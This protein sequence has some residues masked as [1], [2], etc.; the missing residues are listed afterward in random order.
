MQPDVDKIRR[1]SAREVADRLALLDGTEVGGRHR[2]AAYDGSHWIQFYPDGAWHNHKSDWGGDCISLVQAHMAGRPDYRPATADAHFGEAIRQIAEA[3]SLWRSLEGSRR[4]SHRLAKSTRPSSSS[5]THAL[6]MAGDYRGKVDGKREQAEAL[7]TALGVDPERV[8]LCPDGAGT[9]ALCWQPAVPWQGK[10]VSMR[11]DGSVGGWTRERAQKFARDEAALRVVCIDLDGIT[12]TGERPRFDL[13]ERAAGDLARMGLP[14]TAL[15]WSSFGE[16]E[17]RAKAHLYFA[18]TQR[19]Q[20]PAEWRSWWRLVTGSLA[21]VVSNWRDV[22]ERERELLAVD[23]GTEQITR[24]VRLPGYKK[25]GSSWAGVVEW[26]RP[27]V[28]VDFAAALETTDVTWS[29]LKG[30]VRH[31]FTLGERCTYTKRGGDEPTEVLL[32]RRVWPLARYHTPERDDAGLYLRVETLDGLTRYVTVS[33]G[34]L[35]DK[36]RRMGATQEI[37]GAGAQVPPVAGD[38]LMSALGQLY[39]RHE[40]L[41]RRGVLVARAGWHDDSY[42]LGAEVIGAGGTEVL[43]DSTSEM[44]RRRGAT[45]GSLEGWREQVVDRCTTPGLRLALGASLA[46]ALMR[47]LQ[48]H[49]FVLHVAGPSSVGKSTCAHVAA[50]VWGEPS[51][52]GV[53]QSWDTT[54]RAL[55][56]L[57]ELAQDACLV[58]DEVGRW[59][60]SPEDLAGALHALGGSEGRARL[61]QDGALS[62]QRTWHCT[63]VSTGEVRLMDL[64][65]DHMQGGHAVRALDVWL[66]QGEASESAAHAEGIKRGCARHHGVAARAFV[67]E[68]VD[69]DW[70]EL[71]A[72]VQRVVEVLCER[73]GN[74]ASG[75]V[76]RQAGSVAV[77][78]IA[79]GLAQ[80]CGLVPWGAEERQALAEW[81]LDRI[82]SARIAQA[83][84]TPEHRMLR[85]LVGVMDETEERAPW[86]VGLGLSTK[87]R[88]LV[89]IRDGRGDTSVA[90]T[91]RQWLQRSG[92]CERAGVDATSWL[93]WARERGLAD[94]SKYPATIAGFRKRFWT[95]NMDAVE[96]E[97]TGE[98]G[99]HLEDE[100]T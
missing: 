3:F 25:H 60:G 55:E 92:L 78:I 42:V 18:G 4:S 82:V 17:N 16:D 91:T 83:V 20:T 53:Y 48:R 33:A 98:S 54:S 81:A 40:T 56:G 57:A 51:A 47:K 93:R 90:H 29:Y 72:R 74:E 62:A 75:E 64:L 89:A 39:S 76:R 23:P 99:A 67:A 15:V 80:A 100:K 36:S 70:D 96:T 97:L 10:P 1:L 58:L 88:N 34:R 49:P 59:R 50:S 45:S 86:L 13:V 19:A 12:A 30:D 8:T 37:I 28:R 41:A 46:G 31:T 77:C 68:L 6:D 35:I 84:H 44:L 9:G 65:G 26:A 5:Y 24:L 27:D 11:E 69:A 32:G 52:G 38:G 22:P 94:Q 71:E 95:L 63:T 2:F 14:V 61:R 79:L 73:L 21:G 43:P 87:A 66:T 85:A 7:L